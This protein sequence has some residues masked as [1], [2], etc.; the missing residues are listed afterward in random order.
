MKPKIG[1]FYMV[2][3]NGLYR[4]YSCRLCTA[5]DDEG[6]SSLVG[7]PG[8]HVHSIQDKEYSLTTQD[9]TRLGG[10][11]VCILGVYGFWVFPDEGYDADDDN[12]CKE[13]DI[14]IADNEQAHALL[15]AFPSLAP[16]ASARPLL[17]NPLNVWFEAL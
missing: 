12:G 17:G 9:T 13:S 5:I 1:E 16:Y 10:H 7:E 6:C 8:E 3:V 4:P 14:Y 15:M 2:P 11:G